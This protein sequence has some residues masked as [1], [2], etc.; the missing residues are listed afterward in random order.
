[1]AM[2][3]KETRPF[4]RLVSTAADNV[5]TTTGS[6]HL[7]GSGLPHLI[8]DVVTTGTWI[9]RQGRDSRPFALP[10]GVTPAMSV[11]ASPEEAGERRLVGFTALGSAKSVSAGFFVAL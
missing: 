2:N 4:R 5:S 11:M 3:R 7:T 1:M 9:P 6:W 10:A 8:V